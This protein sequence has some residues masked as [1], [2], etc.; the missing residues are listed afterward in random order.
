MQA[1]YILACSG[2]PLWVLFRVMLQQVQNY[3]LLGTALHSPRSESLLPFL[4]CSLFKNVKT[5][6]TNLTYLATIDNIYIYLI[7]YIWVTCYITKWLCTM[8]LIRWIQFGDDTNFLGLKRCV[9]SNLWLTPWKH[10]FCENCGNSFCV[11]SLT[12]A[13][14]PLRNSPQGFHPLQIHIIIFYML[15]LYIIAHPTDLLLFNLFLHVSLL[16]FR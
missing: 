14:M 7:T 13:M 12:I 5:S 4:I 15:F 2:V 8:L 3:L 10:R 11:F 16:F 1:I 6:K 9:L